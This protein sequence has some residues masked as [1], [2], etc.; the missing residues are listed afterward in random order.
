LDK[1]PLLYAIISAVLFGVSSPLSKLLLGDI[2]PVALAGLLYLGAF[3]GLSIYSLATWKKAGTGAN[4]AAPLEKK[5]WPWLLGATLAGG[6]IAPIS[7]M[8][9]LNLISGFSTSL[10]LNM[11]GVCTAIIAVIVFKEN[12]GRNL[13]IALLC[14]TAA[15][16]FLSWDTSQS[17]FNVLGPLLIVLATF[18]WGIDNNLTRQISEKSPLQITMI[19]GLIAGTVSLSAALILNQSVPLD[20]SIL[21]ALLLGAFSVGISLVFFIKALKGLGASR[22]GTFFSTGPF[23]GAIASLIIF[24]NWNEWI[25]IP[26]FLFM[27]AGMWFIFNERHVHTHLH[28]FVT[29]IHSHRHDDLHHTHEHQPLVSGTHTHAH[30]HPEL[31]HTHVHWPDTHHRHAHQGNNQ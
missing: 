25:I 23:V 4:K 28:P 24:K 11:E 10:L 7:M 26:A 9:G 18:C 6:I 8:L 12:A 2:P 15:G 1:K 22:T 3:A 16:V 21:Y 20:I 31:S 19:K 5:D 17:K 29:H 14:M 30:T 27:A 13:W